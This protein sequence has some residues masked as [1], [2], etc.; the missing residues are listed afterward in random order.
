[1]T[2]QDRQIVE[3]TPVSNDTTTPNLTVVQKWQT[4]SDM[5][6][7][8]SNL[9]DM[10]ELLDHV[11]TLTAQRFGLDVAMFFLHDVANN[12]LDLNA[13]YGLP[14]DLKPQLQHLSVNE[15]DDTLLID[16][17]RQ[18]RVI[19]VNDMA[20][21]TYRVIDRERADIG[22]ELAL[23]IFINQELFG[24]LNFQSR[25]SH[26]FDADTVVVFTLF[27]RQVSVCCDNARLWSYF[28]GHLLRIFEEFQQEISERKRAE[29]ELI[30]ARDQAEAASRA[31][32]TFLATMSHELRTPLNV[33]LGVVQIMQNDPA[34]TSDHQE[35]LQLIYNNGA[36]LLD[37][38]NDVL[39]VSKIEAG[40]LTLDESN[41]SLDQLL[42]ALEAMFQ[43]RADNKGLK[44][45]V[46]VE[47]D[48]PTYIRTDERKLRQVL[49]NLLSNAVKYTPQ[50]TITFRSSCQQMDDNTVILFF[51]VSDT[52]MGIDAAEMDL[53]FEAFAQ[54]SSGRQ[55]QE[56]TGL[57]LS[58]SQQFVMMMG[59]KINVESEVGQ[60]STF[61]FYIQA[62]LA[63]GPD[64]SLEEAERRVI[65]IAPGQP[66]YRVLIVEDKS[67]IRL[68]IRKLLEP[69]GFEVRE[70]DNGRVAVE[71]HDEWEPHLIFM[72]MRMPVMNGFQATQR[73]R[74]SLKG[75]AT[76]IIAMT[77]TAQKD[78]RL[79]LLDSGC[80]DFIT[81]PFRTAEVYEKIHQL[82]GV[83]FVYVEETDTPE[84]QEVE[85]FDP[86]MIDT[87]PDTWRQA[88]REAIVVADQGQL[89]A[90]VTEIQP[91]HPQ[92]ARYLLKLI[93]Q[94]SLGTLVKLFQGDN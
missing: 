18:Q 51:E 6:F 65:G 56:G 25:Q 88:F 53:V 17:V 77:A 35:N 8:I 24:V 42:N 92:A 9:F 82:L 15:A 28:R 81:K 84:D 11:V 73:I 75:Q 76:A 43:M 55:V 71:I 68:L 74:G 37:L 94:F 85:L 50:G 87:L 26:F 19:V 66:T 78:E 22:A 69:L 14:A 23:P 3:K 48:L 83:R 12:T 79:M 59:G 90:L 45:I 31:K 58:I 93:D 62:G 21:T 30:E 64:V 4:M 5:V 63:S 33:I 80:D 13:H 47:P 57:G 44:F 27:G 52:G 10:D 49:T 91:E 32:G 7:K 86:A 70:A 20:E 67:D 34:M 2:G 41:F 38:I 60:G 46:E 39:K 72:D 40:H 61:K 89:R 29:T 36:H 54:T 16:V 1:M